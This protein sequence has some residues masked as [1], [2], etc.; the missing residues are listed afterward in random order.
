MVRSVSG[1]P[2]TCSAR[3]FSCDLRTVTRFP[4][5]GGTQRARDAAYP[6][7]RSPRE[8]CS[9]WRTSCADS[10]L[11]PWPPLRYRTKLSR[12]LNV[13]CS[14]DYT[15]FPPPRYLQISCTCPLKIPLWC[16]RSAR[17]MS[18]LSEGPV[19]H[20][21]HRSAGKSTLQEMLG[22]SFSLNSCQWTFRK[23]RKLKTHAHSFMFSTKGSLS[24]Y[25]NR[26]N[27]WK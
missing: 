25:N 24:V 8:W 3:D 7:G 4:N 2:K 14:S 6:S 23:T 9:P 10:E 19:R 22:F 15:K 1:Q 16:C 17:Q 12:F 5:R 11:C 21:I 20:S 26:C 18:P 27:I 13:F